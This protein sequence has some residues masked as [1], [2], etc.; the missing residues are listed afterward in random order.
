[1]SSELMAN[2]GAQRFETTERLR[3]QLYTKTWNCNIL[4]QKRFRCELDQ[5]NL[6]S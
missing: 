5:Y 1:M 4:T 3:K 6:R 2:N